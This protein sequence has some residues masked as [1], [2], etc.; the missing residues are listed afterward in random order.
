VDDPEALLRRRATG[1]TRRTTT[2]AVQPASQQPPAQTGINTMLSFLAYPPDTAG[3]AIHD[4][5]EQEASD[6]QVSDEAS[7][8]EY[9]GEEDNRPTPRAEQTD[10]DE[11]YQTAAMTAYEKETETE[12]DDGA[13]SEY[14]SGL[15]AFA[16]FTDGPAFQQTVNP[17]PPLPSRS[18]K[19]AD[20]PSD[21][22]TSPD[23][24]TTPVHSPR[25]EAVPPPTR[26]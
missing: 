1:S 8:D 18:A 5:S 6:E 26:A 15:C 7:E 13:E 23:P 21:T 12:T 9:S 19:S 17:A 22:P 20:T 16:N 25:P 4:P 10:I 2:D 11:G 14:V 3:P 24:G